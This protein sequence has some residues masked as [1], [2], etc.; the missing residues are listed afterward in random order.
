[1][2]FFLILNIHVSVCTM[3]EVD[4]ELGRQVTAFDKAHDHT[5]SKGLA[6]ALLGTSTTFNVCLPQHPVVLSFACSTRAAI[7]PVHAMDAQR[8]ILQRG[9]S[10]RS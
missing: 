1:M 5:F 8:L 10:R 9:R 4:P 3:Q 2:Y 7:P 6:F